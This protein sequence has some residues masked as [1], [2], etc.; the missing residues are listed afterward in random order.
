[1]RES[2]KIV[3][4]LQG[5]RQAQDA[6]VVKPMNAVT[7]H[8]TDRETQLPLLAECEFEKERVAELRARTRARKF[9][10]SRLL[11]DEPA[12]VMAE[13]LP[14]KA[15][16]LAVS[17]LVAGSHS[18]EPREQNSNFATIGSFRVRPL[19]Q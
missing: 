6:A 17:A 14:V 9:G 1:M 2:I 10:L 13:I 19:P 11:S 4:L 12:I 5:Q 18:P 16:L 8:I 7:H 15:T 3:R